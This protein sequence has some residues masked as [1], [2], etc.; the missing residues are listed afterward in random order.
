MDCKFYKHSRTGN[1]Y[2]V[3][4][5]GKMKVENGWTVCIVYKCERSGEIY[6]REIKDFH[7]KFTEV[8]K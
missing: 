1:T 5:K 7:N 8:E 2:E 6:C 4:H 3:L